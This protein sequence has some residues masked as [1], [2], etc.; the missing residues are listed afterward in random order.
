MWT[1]A[2]VSAGIDLALALV[3]DDCGHDVAMEVA[4]ELVVFLKR[5]GGQSQFSELLQA[6]ADDTAAF[7]EL[8][9]WIFGNL[10]RPDLTVETLAQRARMSPRNFVRKGPEGGAGAVASL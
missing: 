4:R 10:E 6:Q 8:N 5:P 3:E 9:L 2:G 1:S 7:D